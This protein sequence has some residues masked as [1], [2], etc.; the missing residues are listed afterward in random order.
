MP[1]TQIA[2][3]ELEVREMTEARKIVPV[4]D[5]P[6]A[7]MT[8]MAMI[9]RALTLGATPETLEKLMAL[10]ER[11]EATEARRE[12]NEAMALAKTELK[13]VIKNQ[14]ANFGSGKAAYDYEDMLAVSRVVDPIFIK[15][16]L[17]YRYT[18]HV[19]G[20]TVTVT[21][22][23]SHRRGHREETTL[24][25][26]ADTSGS[27]NPVQAVGSTVTYLQRYTLKLAAGLAAAKD[28]DGTGGNP[29]FAQAITADQFSELRE[30]LEESGSQEAAMLAFVKA[31][32]IEEMTIAQ[33]AKA[34]AAMAV[35]ISQKRQ[36][37]GK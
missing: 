16:G 20:N 34:K 10:Q 25:A 23:V 4:I 18:S 28:D 7:V 22:I 11:W 24:S 37:A 36:R 1:L 14:N 32:C 6:Q 27:K 30:M 13:P 33:Y 8:P 5:Q 15:H 35:K 2:L 17:S 31:E 12:F 29:D 19:E 9:D 26:P 21:C 3:K